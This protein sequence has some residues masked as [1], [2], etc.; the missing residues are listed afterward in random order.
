MPFIFILLS[1]F[2]FGLFYTSLSDKASAQ[3]R[4]QMFLISNLWDQNSDGAYQKTMLKVV[5]IVL[6]TRKSIIC[7]F[8]L[9]KLQEVL[10]DSPQAQILLLIIFFTKNCWIFNIIYMNEEPYFLK[11]NIWPNLLF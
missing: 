10:V 7:N 3:Y 11:E 5:K 4:F 9:R 8:V 6:E 1:V 2:F